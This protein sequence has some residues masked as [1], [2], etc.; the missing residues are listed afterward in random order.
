V[1]EV[2][3]TDTTQVVLEAPLAPPLRVPPVRVMVDAPGFAVTGVV[4]VEPQLPLSPFWLS[5][6]SPAGSVSV[7]PIPVSV[8]LEFV[9]VIVNASEADSPT[10]IPV[11][12]EK[13]VVI[14]GGVAA[15]AVAADANAVSS[16]APTMIASAGRVV[17]A[18]N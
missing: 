18:L 8:P 5:I 9:S 17:I 15:E 10:A 13:A 2:T 11:V 14:V 1:F 6:T 12:G 4:A 7:N 16:A 3:S